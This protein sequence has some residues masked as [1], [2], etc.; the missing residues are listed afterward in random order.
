M[1]QRP[2]RTTVP[3]AI[4]GTLE[5]TRDLERLTHGPWVVV[6]S[7]E[8]LPDGLVA[9]PYQGTWTAPTDATLQPLRFRWLRGG[10]IEIQGSTS[11][12]VSGTTIFTLPND[13]LY[14]QFTL[15]V[16]KPASD[17]GGNFVVLRVQ[18]TGAVVG[19]M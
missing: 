16:R 17:D 14:R 3:G 13:A 12:G 4:G 10:G 1:T 19:G 5:R 15:E 2:L 18:P 8:V 9:P 7:G 6:G 11:G